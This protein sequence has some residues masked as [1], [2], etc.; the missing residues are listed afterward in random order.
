MIIHHSADLFWALFSKCITSQNKKG[1]EQ[2][3]QVAVADTSASSGA[4]GAEGCLQGSPRLPEALSTAWGG[5][6]PL[7]SRL[8][9]SS[10]P[11]T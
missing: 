11:L 10:L 5:L 3:H 9:S 1:R 7:A 8:L 4:G 2:T 6:G